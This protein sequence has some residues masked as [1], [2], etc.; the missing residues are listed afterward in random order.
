MSIFEILIILFIVF[1]FIKRIIDGIKQQGEP[2][3]GQQPGERDNQTGRDPS[4]GSWDEALGELEDLFSGQPSRGSREPEREPESPAR[5]LDKPTGSE[6]GSKSS[7]PEAPIGS[8]DASS[9]L[10]NTENPIYKSLDEAPEVITTE[11]SLKDYSRELHDP[12]AL[13]NAFIL[14]EILDTPS[15][16]RRIRK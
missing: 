14:R 3:P 11:S 8:V 9:D 6:A 2:P 5:P 10:M 4:P 7:S 15:S 16:L 12:Q 13:R 1:P